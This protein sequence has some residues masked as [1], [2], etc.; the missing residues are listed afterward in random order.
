MKTCVYKLVLVLLE[1]N[2]ICC[3]RGQGA[4]LQDT[5]IIYSISV[6]ACFSAEFQLD[7]SDTYISGV[8]SY[9]LT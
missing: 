7:T 3:H 9:G 4:K 1:R 8:T 6:P 5:H 2:N